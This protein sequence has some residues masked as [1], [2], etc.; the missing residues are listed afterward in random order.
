[1]ACNCEKQIAS[2]AVKQAA[3]A[4][5]QYAPTT[6]QI[7]FTDIPTAPH[8]VF[9]YI[10]SH[11]PI[12]KWYSSIGSSPFEHP[13]K[14]RHGSQCLSQGIVHTKCT[15]AQT[16]SSNSINYIFDS[17]R[18]I[19]N[20]HATLYSPR[21]SFSSRSLGALPSS[22]AHLPCHPVPSHPCNPP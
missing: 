3:F 19:Y 1:V 13:K 20:R 21:R 10:P 2:D 14:I 16:K 9:T 7:G 15:E 6:V 22:P 4:M 17:T 12:S 11:I 8:S 5:T 18:T